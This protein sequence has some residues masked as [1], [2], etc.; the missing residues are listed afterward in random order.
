[1]DKERLEYLKY[2][3]YLVNKKWIDSEIE[4]L[5]LAPLQGIVGLRALRAKV[6]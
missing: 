1:L 6:V 2:L 4:E 3:N 5:E